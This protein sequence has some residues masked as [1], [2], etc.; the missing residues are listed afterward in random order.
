MSD[1]RS[2]YLSLRGAGLRNK[3]PGA[4]FTVGSLSMIGMP[5]LTGFVSKY[6]FAAAATTAG[7][8]MITAWVVLAISTVLNTMYFMRTVLT[9]YRPVPEET[10]KAYTVEKSR[11]ETAAIIGMILL[12]IGLGVASQPVIKVIALFWSCNVLIRRKKWILIIIY[13]SGA[14]PIIAGVLLMFIK[15]G[16]REHMQLYILLILVIDLASIEGSHRARAIH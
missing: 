14:S 8:K 10:H 13:F 2:D 11:I 12:N 15:F 9:L 5:L 7:S 1:G 6:L 4:A 16:K 3:V